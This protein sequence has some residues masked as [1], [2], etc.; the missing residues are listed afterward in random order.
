M[1]GDSAFWIWAQQVFG[2]GSPMPW[3]IY[4]NFPGGLEGFY[5]SGPRCWNALDYITEQQAAALNKI[6]LESAQVKLEYA[7]KLGW[8]VVTPECEKYPGRL[9]NISDPPA[10]LYKKGE[11]PD[12]E[13]V[14]FVAVVGARK[15]TEESLD[16]ARTIGFQLASGGAVVVSGGA[17][18]VDGGALSGAVSALG[19]GVSILP[20][21]LDS[22]YLAK[23]MALRSKL[24]ETGGALLSE[25]FFQRNPGRGSFH[26]RNRLITGI[27]HCV[28]LIQAG[29]KS[30][31]MIYARH[32]AKQG[33]ELF[34]YPGPAGAPEYVGSRRLIQKGA[35]MVSSGWE[36][37]EYLSGLGGSFAP[38]AVWQDQEPH[39]AWVP[40]IG[41]NAGEEREESQAPLLADSSKE[42]SPQERQILRLLEAGE[43]TIDELKDQTGLEAGELLGLLTQMELEGRVETA[44]GQRYRR[45]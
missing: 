27:C 32:A 13:S 4:R 3:Y 39:A 36:I 45:S 11:L 15:A 20:V 35:R 9:R 1:V 26:Q 34:V 8:N 24:L 29:E 10:V 5:R 30:G 21:D 42:R 12:W 6:R 2:E 28:V 31:T 22:P 43:K 38:A 41:G 37:L 25:Y 19:S 23:N 7:Q 16:F 18:G 40:R 14:P 33:R 17:V 44:P